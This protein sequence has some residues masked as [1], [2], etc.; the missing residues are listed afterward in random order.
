M[1]VFALTEADF[2]GKRGTAEA[3]SAGE[4]IAKQL[5]GESG[6]YTPV[7]AQTNALMEV[8]AGTSDFAVI[9]ILMANAMVGQ[10]D[11]ADLE[12]N[13]AYTPKPEV[14]AIG[15]RKG[16]DFTAKINEAIK[17]LSENGKLAE[18]AAKYNVSNSLIEN[19][20]A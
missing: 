1:I 11:Y 15:C 16:S 12:I 4:A 13:T 20:G 7:T 9:D 17:T 6:T 5:T 3:S 2:T 10:G 19:I 8:L 14:Y 18:I